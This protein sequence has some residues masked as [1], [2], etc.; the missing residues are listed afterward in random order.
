MRPYSTTRI[1]HFDNCKY[2]WKKTYIDGIKRS[3]NDYMQG[4]ALFHRLANQ[5]IQHLIKTGQPTDI[6][7][8]EPI[9]NNNIG[10]ETFG[11]IDGYSELFRSWAQNQYIFND[12][13]ISIYT[14]MKIA[15]DA[16]FC[17]VGISNEDDWE[18][19]KI[20]LRGIIDRINLDDYNVEIIDYK[21]YYSIP[22]DKELEESLQTKIYPLLV[23]KILDVRDKIIKM[24]YEFVRFGIKK[25]FIID[26][27][28]FDKTEAWLRKKAEEI[29]NTKEFEATFC[30]YCSYCGVKD[31]CPAMKRALANEDIYMPTN[32]AE[33][34]KLAES[35]LA[36]QEK[37]KAIANFLKLYIT[38]YGP[39][40]IG[41]QE[42]RQ[43]INESYE[44]ENTE[45]F[46]DILKTKGVP[47]EYIWQM[48]SVTKTDFEKIMK[49]AKMADRIKEIVD[50]VGTP[51]ISTMTKFFKVK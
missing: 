34:V 22:S 15:V 8:I 29:E 12:H 10:K 43:N 4:G 28:Q 6:E 51:K 13:E 26:P 47:K 31:S 3:S 32:E 50:E 45:R 23:A 40:R 48:L 37:E 35:L 42:Y 18:S 25:E 49:K 1:E 11:V 27:G 5:Y 38:E 30:E 33:A 24:V 36:I 41:D 44:F 17:P 9:I 20:F 19:D 7:A 2:S 16:D 14:E 21:T 39:V 46:V